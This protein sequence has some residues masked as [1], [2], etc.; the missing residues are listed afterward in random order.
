MR[1]PGSWAANPQG[2]S[3]GCSLERQQR[4]GTA[5]GAGMSLPNLQK[6]LSSC[7]MP[8]DPPHTQQ[9]SAVSLKLTLFC[10]SLSCSIRC[11]PRQLGAFATCCQLCLTQTRLKTP[12]LGTNLLWDLQG[13]AQGTPGTQKSEDKTA[14]VPPAFAVPQDPEIG[15]DVW[16][17]EWMMSEF[18]FFFFCL[19]RK[20]FI[21]ETCPCISLNTAQ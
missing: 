3:A 18:F 5:G 17:Q 1:A 21:L 19:L 6:V 12:R 13:G 7:S 10:H 15:S 9:S 8:P 4:W 14:L 11:P 2:Y 16:G 20:R